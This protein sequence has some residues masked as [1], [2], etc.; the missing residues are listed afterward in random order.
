VFVP[1]KDTEP[2]VVLRTPP[3]PPMQPLMVPVWT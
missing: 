2:V 3:A 1:V